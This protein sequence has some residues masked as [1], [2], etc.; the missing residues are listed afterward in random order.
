MVPSE[1]SQKSPELGRISYFT[2]IS[3]TTCLKW[4]W[5]QAYYSWILKQVG[6]HIR[7]TLATR[8]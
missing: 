4:G 3:C 5:Y 8:V 6:I 1:V 2:K 7:L